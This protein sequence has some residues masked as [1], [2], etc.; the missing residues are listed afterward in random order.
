MTAS[1]LDAHAAAPAAL[2]AFLRGVERRGAVFAELATGSREAGDAALVASMRAFRTLAAQAPFV[3]WPRRFW[4]ILLATPRLRDASSDP[5]WPPAFAVLSKLGSGPR[6]AL[7][8]RLVAGLA[9]ADAAAVLGVARP[10]YRLALQRALPH[11]DDGAPDAAAWQAL[12]GAAQAAIRHLS[13]ERL[14]EIARQREAAI[15]GQKAPPLAVAPK[16]SPEGVR[17][18]RLA[19]AGIA[20]ATALAL[21]ATWWWPG[22]D[23]REASAHGV[24]VEPLPPADAPASRYDDDARLLTHRDFDLLL[25]EEDTPAA[26]D[27]GFH[28]WY[29][30]QLN[31]ARTGE[32][33]EPLPIEDPGIAPVREAGELE[34]ADAPR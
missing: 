28:A 19:Q 25:A 5:A 26:V 4:S 15:R 30:A 34:S 22:G 32:D 12:A 17:P 11:R 27:P 14:A 31:A 2:T 7:L 29:A 10:T 13:P 20:G 8:L 33:A 21:A 3:E 9:E 24:Q 23:G 1:P 16:G 6:A 18:W